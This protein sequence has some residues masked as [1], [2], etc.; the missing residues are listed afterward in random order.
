MFTLYVAPVLPCMGSTA[1][2]DFVK[3]TQVYRK[4]TLHLMKDVKSKVNDDKINV[5]IDIN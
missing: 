4:E 2:N 1:L 5:N 3:W